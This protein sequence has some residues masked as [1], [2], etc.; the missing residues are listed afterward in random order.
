MFG[1]FPDHIIAFIERISQCPAIFPAMIFETISSI[2]TQAPVWVEV[3]GSHTTQSQ[4]QTV[5]I[6]IGYRS[7]DRSEVK[8]TRLFRSGSFHKVFNQCFGSE[9]DVLESRNL[10]YPVHEHIH[11]TLCFG[12]RHLANF[13]PVFITL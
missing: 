3:G 11:A 6:V 7:I 10:F 8:F 1:K 5:H 9:D 4:S 12:E 2:T 13:R